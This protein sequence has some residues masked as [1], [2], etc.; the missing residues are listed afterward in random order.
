M[1]TNI[2]KFL[3]LLC[4]CI[5][6]SIFLIEMIYDILFPEIFLSMP[7]VSLYLFLLS[8]FTH[9][10][11]YLFMYFLVVICLFDAVL[12]T[13]IEFICVCFLYIFILFNFLKGMISQT[14]SYMVSQ[15]QSWVCPSFADTKK[16]YF[17]QLLFIQQLLSTMQIY[18][19]F[20]CTYNNHVNSRQ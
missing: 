18:I 8:F 10:L 16:N 7:Q 4:Q 2:S 6:V 1:E 13:I 5:L 15:N 9:F 11:L 20:Q 12:S 14:N 17:F 19:L 3:N